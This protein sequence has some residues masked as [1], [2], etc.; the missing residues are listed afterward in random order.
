MNKGESWTITLTFSPKEQKLW[1]WFDSIPEE[2]REK[3]V[4]GLINKYGID[5]SQL[6]EEIRGELFQEILQKIRMKIDELEMKLK[7]DHLLFQRGVLGKDPKEEK[8][9]RGELPIEKRLDQLM[10]LF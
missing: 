6:R 8:K 10:E 5:E 7:E 2:E 3:K 4:K 9:G 1:D